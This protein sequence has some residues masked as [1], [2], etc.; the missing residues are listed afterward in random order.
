MFDC[1]NSRT[2]TIKKNKHSNSNASVISNTSSEYS[3]KDRYKSSR[4]CIENDVLCGLIDDLRYSG[5][6]NLRK[7]PHRPS[8]LKPLREECHKEPSLTFDG[9][10]SKSQ[11]VSGPI[12]D[13]G[14]S[15]DNLKLELPVCVPLWTAYPAYS[16]EANRCRD[17]DSDD[18]EC[19]KKVVFDGGNA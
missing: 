2:R 7:T 19:E 18:D 3:V 8:K 16:G 15:S 12:I 17:R 4:K 6:N 11:Y 13:L 9:G 5:R 10:T 1:G 14:T